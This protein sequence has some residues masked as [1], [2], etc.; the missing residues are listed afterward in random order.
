V[1]DV[2]V[3]CRAHEGYPLPSLLPH[4]RG[5][6]LAK[7]LQKAGL[8]A[9]FAAL[10]C[11][12]KVCRV[13]IVSEYESSLDFF[14]KRV[15]PDL[16]RIEAGRH[17]CMADRD[18]PAGSFGSDYRGWF[19][20]RGGVLR[21][22]PGEQQSSYEHYIGVGVDPEVIPLPKPKGPKDVIIFDFPKIGSRISWA[23]FD[24]KFVRNLRKAFPDAV[25]LATG[26]ELF[27]HR[28]Q[29]DC[30]WPYLQKHPRFAEMYTRAFA[31]IPGWREAVGLCVA[32]AQVAGAT[33]IAEAGEIAPAMLV[34]HLPYERAKPDSLIAAL[35][36][37]AEKDP[38]A[39]SAE[40]R[41]HFDYGTVVTR[42]RAAIGL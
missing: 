26:S 3:T 37:A 41:A 11:P 31:Y 19:G 27:P 5:F 2:L 9:E 20:E 34:S 36:T 14:S 42:A 1:L 7:Y 4:V 17:F 23:K 28:S 12:G 16:L 18:A 15:Q 33:I 8:N 6:Y 35:K 24:P 25:L 21:L 39:V 29:F 38:L 32:E 30:W 40:A 22:L 10:P 13:V